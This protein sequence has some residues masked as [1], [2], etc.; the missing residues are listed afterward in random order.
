LRIVR[1]SSR[2]SCP[3]SH[4]S[5]TVSSRHAQRYPGMRGAWMGPEYDIVIVGGGPAGSSCALHLVRR[6]GVSPGRLAILDKAK[7]PLD[8]PCA[9]A[10]SQLG[11]DTLTAI[12]VGIGVPFVSMNG[13]RVLSGDEI[14]ETL[15]RMGVCIRR[16]EFD[17]HL[18]TTARA[19]GVHVA[20][21]DGLDG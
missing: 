3:I 1:P 9:G 7:F 10:V 18:L 14:G 21:G 20:D 2:N 15:A 12:G 4:A 8:K 5:S 19:D 11:I 13:V 16:T 17:A 6:E